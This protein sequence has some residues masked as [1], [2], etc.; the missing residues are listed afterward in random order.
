MAELREKIERRHGSDWRNL[1]L[2]VLPSTG[3]KVAAGGGALTTLFVVGSKFN[4]AFALLLLLASGW[5][6]ARTQPESASAMQLG[7]EPAGFSS[8]SEQPEVRSSDSSRRESVAPTA[9]KDASLVGGL[10][11]QGAIRSSA[12]EPVPSTRVR[13]RDE[14]RVLVAIDE[15]AAGWYAVSGLSPGR[16]TVEADAERFRKR[17]FELDLDGSTNPGRFDL[18]LDPTSFV[19]VRFVDENGKLVRMPHVAGSL[20]QELGLSVV[21]TSEKPSTNLTPSANGYVWFGM[22]HWYSGAESFRRPAFVDAGSSGALEIL[23]DLPCFASLIVRGRVLDSKLVARASEAVEFPLDL[24]ALQKERAGVRI[25]FV[26]ARTHE[27]IASLPVELHPAW[28]SGPAVNTDTSGV[29]AF[30][31]LPLV[32]LRLTYRGI[33]RRVELQSGAENDLGTIEVPGE[34][35]L[36][37]RIVDEDGRPIDGMVSW[38]PL[39][40]GVSAREFSAYRWWQVVA[41]KQAEVTALDSRLRLQAGPGTDL[42]GPTWTCNGAIVE[43]GAEALNIELHAV[44]GVELEIAWH[45]RPEGDRDLL[46]IAADGA[47]SMRLYAAGEDSKILRLGAGDYGV[48]SW[49]GTQRLGTQTISVRPGTRRIELTL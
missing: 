8:L 19:Q 13:F 23:G 16:Y 1:C 49:Q 24:P 4:L 33:Q 40:P 22:G 10:F 30:E 48:E 2:F 6:A 15:R 42:L 36:H 7:V 31:D 41:G 29:V 43:P 34:R 38:I 25:R 37:V 45:A 14:S 5:Y 18:T 47:P 11:C 26:D 44:R 3:A 21:A 12:G 9:R 39:E 35:K 20:E 27:P 28:R 32:P 46:F 17:S